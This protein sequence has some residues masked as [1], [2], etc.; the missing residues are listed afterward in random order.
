[1]P[2]WT[3]RCSNATKWACHPSSSF[4]NIFAN[5]RVTPGSDRE[6][7]EHYEL[8][9]SATQPQADIFELHVKLVD[10]GLFRTLRNGAVIFRSSIK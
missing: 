8:F 7:A 9:G 6:I 4:L 3:P 2:C 5:N 1:M 10:S